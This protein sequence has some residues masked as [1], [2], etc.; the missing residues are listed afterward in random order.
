MIHT[1][2]IT[3]G[4]VHSVI[5]MAA[6]GITDG[7]VITITGIALITD[8]TLTVHMDTAVGMVWDTAVVTGTIT[9]IQVLS[10]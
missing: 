2:L 8:G 5:I 7:A 6:A 4:L 9:E 10:L 1:G 3:V